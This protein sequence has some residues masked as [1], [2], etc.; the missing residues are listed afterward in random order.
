MIPA[1]G[2]GRRCTRSTFPVAAQVEAELV[3]HSGRAQDLRAH[4]GR[5][6]SLRP[7]SPLLPQAHARPA[8]VLVN[9]LKTGHLNFATGEARDAR[10]VEIAERV[11]RSVRP[12]SMICF[13]ELVDGCAPLRAS[14]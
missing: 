12:E 10:A 2:A 3:R 6:L 14:I 11:A 9:E 7:R 5:G 1:T 13:A 8:A 4:P